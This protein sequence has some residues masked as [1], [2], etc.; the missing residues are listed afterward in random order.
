VKRFS[1]CE[2][3]CDPLTIHKS[4]TN[5]S[6][7]ETLLVEVNPLVETST[8]CHKNIDAHPKHLIKIPWTTHTSHHLLNFSFCCFPVF[9]FVQIPLIVQLPISPIIAACWASSANIDDHFCPSLIIS[10]NF[11]SIYG[12][13]TTY[14]VQHN[15]IIETSILHAKLVQIFETC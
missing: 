4:I 7:D 12:R 15:I 13:T 8:S 9:I 3:D 1:A 6:I 11:P 10:A 5:D 2:N 14:L